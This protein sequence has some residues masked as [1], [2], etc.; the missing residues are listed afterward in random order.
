MQDGFVTRKI[1][2]FHYNTQIIIILP[3]PL[4]EEQ[5]KSMERKIP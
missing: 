5:N 4:A 1:T 3:T 2:E